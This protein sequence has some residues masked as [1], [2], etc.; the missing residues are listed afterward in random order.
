VGR[1]I[2]HADETVGFLIGQYH[3]KTLSQRKNSAIRIIPH[4]RKSGFAHA[5]M[6]NITDKV[7]FT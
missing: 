1:A 3:A 5:A 7:K 4:G 2:L 6:Y